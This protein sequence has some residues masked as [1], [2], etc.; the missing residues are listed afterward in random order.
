[1][2]FKHL[3]AFYSVAKHR[4]FTRA[5]KE[6]NVSQPT[7]SLQVAEVE[8]YLGNPLIQRGSRILDLTDEGH[9]VFS[10]AEKIFGLSDELE[11]E[12][13]DL[14][15][16][17]T[18][19][20]KIGVAYVSM[21]NLVPALISELKRR[22][23]KVGLQMFSGLSQQILNKVINYE[24]HVG[25]IARIKYPDN[26]VYREMAKEALYYV[27]REHVPKVINLKDLAGRPIVMQAEGAAHREIIIHEFHKR[28]IP[29]NICIETE[30]PTTQKTM[31]ELGIGGSFLPL[32]T[33]EEDVKKKRFNMARIRDG[34]YFYFDAVFLKERRKSRAIRAIL[35]AID[36]FKPR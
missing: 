12:F 14:H 13:A 7:V 26:L 19:T 25:I 20:L 9:I 3:K 17:N 29:L 31:T 27:T 35:S 36:C 18:G 4:S 2:N 21:K 22:H 5:C 11:K 23:P 8:R 28:G 16:L 30:D 6:L 33:V 15:N 24:Y 34:L 10:Y 32:S 1:M